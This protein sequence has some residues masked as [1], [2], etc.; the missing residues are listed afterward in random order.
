MIQLIQVIRL[1]INKIIYINKNKFNQAKRI[2]ASLAKKIND[3]FD[4]SQHA[5]VNKNDSKIR[6]KNFKNKHTH[7]VF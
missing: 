4:A 1:N 2:F 5:N 3:S 6:L 7:A